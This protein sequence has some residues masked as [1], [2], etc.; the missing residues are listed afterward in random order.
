MLPAI[1]RLSSR[2]AIS[3]VYQRGTFGR[4]GGLLTIKATPQAK[5]AA[6]L[7]PPTRAVVVV[8]KKVDKRAVVRNRLR[9]QVAESFRHLVETAGPGYDIV[10]TIQVDFRTA[11]PVAVRN[12]LTQALQRSGVW[13]S[14]S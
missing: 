1:H 14:N 8:S 3:R 11:E 2:K 6:G 9:R 10:I 7:T 5:T 13:Q 4:G 12:A